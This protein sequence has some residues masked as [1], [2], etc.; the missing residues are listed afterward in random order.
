MT[1][2]STKVWISFLTS[3][4]IFLI[5]G[6]QLG[7]RL[8]LLIGFLVA[9]LLNFFV[10]YYGDNRILAKLNATRLKGQDAWGLIE[11]VQYVSEKLGM[12]VPT[13]YVT[14]H[15]SVNA[16]VVGHS[17]KVGA[18]GF[19]MGLLEKLND[20]ELESV[21]AHQ[22]CH[23][24]NLDTFSFGVT[25]T[26][27]NSIVGLG[28]FLD[29][30]LPYNLKF[31]MPLLSPLGWIII[32]SVIVEKSF[33]ENDL[34]AAKVLGDRIRLGE[35]LWRM[36]GLAQTKPLEIPPCT[37]H[38]FMVNPEGFKQ[39]NLFLKSHPAIAVR[40]QKLVGYYPI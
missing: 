22:L 35:I 24:H 11:K 25:S 14:P 36:E 7:E 8:G 33:F 28:Q 4:L 17:W 18:L 27:A 23:I 29:S 34:M 40:L 38:L 13:I 15:K 10:F 19:T 21:V 30:L 37:S 12:P 1:N 20:E 16:F 6:Y 2:N 3:S 39:K 31:F 5:I 9:L 26:L 32:K